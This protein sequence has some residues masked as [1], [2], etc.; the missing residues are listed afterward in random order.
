MQVLI[1]LTSRTFRPG[2]L[3]QLLKDKARGGGGGGGGGM[4]MDVT[5]V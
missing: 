4:L 2:G 1:L 3:C 5:N